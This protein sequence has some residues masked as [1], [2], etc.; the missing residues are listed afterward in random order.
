M[1]IC[2]RS[3]EPSAILKFNK[4]DFILNFVLSVL[5][6]NLKTEPF[7]TVTR[8]WKK[9]E[10][11]YI[12]YVSR[13]RPNVPPPWSITINLDKGGP[14][15]LQLDSVDFFVLS[16]LGTCLARYT[17][18]DAVDERFDALICSISEL[19]GRDNNVNFDL[20]SEWYRPVAIVQNNAT[21]W[22]IKL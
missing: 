20:N 9:Y 5:A 16:F 17:K 19:C 6:I 1:D 13:L 14:S 22:D 10:K 18:S 8:K 21:R 11:Q 12:Y 2:N 4:T 15:L 7:I 3:T